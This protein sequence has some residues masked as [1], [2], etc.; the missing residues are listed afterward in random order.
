MESN[1]PIHDNSLGRRFYFS[2][3]RWH[4]YAGLFVTPFL[5]VLAL[6]GMLM[7]YLAV[8]DGRDGEKITVAPMGEIQSYSQQADA[9]M[10]AFPDGKLVEMISPLTA[11]SAS[12]FRIS[13]GDIQNMVAVDPYRAEVLETWV[14]RDGWYDFAS[15]IHGTLLIGDLGDRLIEIAA[16]FAIVLVITGLYLWWPRNGKGF[17]QMLVPDI[18]AKGRLWWKSLH[19][20]IGF[21]CSVLLVAFL[22][23]GLSWSGIWGEKF[24]QAWSTFPAEKWDNVP[25]SDDTHA[26]MNHGA[27]KDVPWGLEQTLM[28]ESGSGAGVEGLPE[29][30]PINVDSIAMLGKAL[31][32]DGRYHVNFPK[33]DK[34]VWTI[35]QDSMSNDSNDPMSDQTVHIDQYTGKIVA[36]VGFADYSIPAQAMAVGIA[37]H[38]GDMG[39]WNLLLNTV[40]CLSIIFLSVSG[41]VM[42][43]I[44]R[45]EKSG[46]LGAP[47][48]V[49]VALGKGAVVLTLL[50]SLLFPLAGL[51]LLAV[52]ALDVL[53]IQRIKPLV[54]I[55]S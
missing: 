47:P 10:K 35:S 25:L 50:V 41:V 42:W 6:T 11:D 20:T 23:S 53:I 17:R 22:L 15:N 21:Y 3:W 44:R 39:L 16:G 1:T 29:G 43:W 31:V 28:P 55:L 51:T 40:F 48:M 24:T 37:F 30:T 2:V 54:R 36:Q 18:F 7:M 12:V 26:S 45:P 38:E 19:Q 49:D 46:R 8:F 13:V 34:G 33:N 27:I 5:M 9:A 52:L 32:E 4:F 14:R